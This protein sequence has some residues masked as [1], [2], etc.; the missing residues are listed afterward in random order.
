MTPFRKRTP[1]CRG[2]DE[3]REVWEFQI[4]KRGWPV[5]VQPEFTMIGGDEIIGSTQW[6]G[7]DGRRHELCQVLTVGKIVDVQGCRSRREAEQ[8]ARRH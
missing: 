8:F 3:A 4:K 1:S 2:P 6:T 5:E 7:G